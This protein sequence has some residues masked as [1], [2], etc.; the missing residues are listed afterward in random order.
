M[1]NRGND[2]EQANKRYLIELLESI[3]RPG[4]YC[5][6]GNL[7]VP[8]PQITLKNMGTLSFPV[9]LE[10]IEA[11]IDMAERAPYGKGT[12][13][14]MDMSVR[15]CWQIDARQIRIS[16]KAWTNSFKK[17]MNLVSKG[18]GIDQGQ[19]GAKLYKLLIYKEG[20]F[21][22]A[23]RDTEKVPRMIATLSLSLPTPGEGGELSVR[24]ADLESVFNMNA[25]EPSELS[26]A[27]F[28]ADCLHEVRPVTKGHRIS[29]VYNLFL[30]SEKKWTGAPD[31]TELRDKVEK[32]LVDWIDSGKTEKIVWMLAHS[33]SE[34]GLSFDTL[35]GTDAAVARVLGEAADHAGCDMHTATLHIQ[36]TGTPD[37]DYDDSY[38]S[39]PKIGSTIMEDLDREEHLENWTAHDGSH[40]PFGEILV[41]TGELLPID[42]TD[43]LCPDE[44]LLEEYMGNY[45]PTL[46]L[47]YRLGALVVWP[48]SNTLEIIARGGIG[49]AVSW[50]ATRCDHVSRAE[51]HRLLSKLMDIWP[52]SRD[53]YKDHNR[54]VMLQILST[55]GNADLA[56]DF[57]DQTVLI[58]YNGSENEQLA[59][60]MPVV[61]PESAKEFLPKLV[62][63]YLLDYPKE[64]LALCT[65]IT[66]TLGQTEPA[67]FN[68]MRDVV[69]SVLSLLRTVLEKATE[70]V[71]RVPYKEVQGKIEYITWRFDNKNPLD[72]AAICDLFA[73]TWHL[74]LEQESVKA[75]TTIAEFTKA[76]T[77]DRMLPEALIDLYKI[78]QVSSTETYRLLWRQSVDI[79]TQRS[80][81]PP[82]KPTNWTINANVPGSS[83]LL[84]KLQAFCLNPNRRTI[85]FKVAKASRRHIHETIKVLGLDIDHTTERKGSPHTLHC[86]KN[87][88]GHKRRLAEYSEDIRYIEHL[89]TLVPKGEIENVDAKR[90][91]RLEAAKAAFQDNQ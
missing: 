77:P 43:H 61:G 39:E 26:Y 25:Q 89:L 44:E 13:T 27:A 47:I 38:W 3:D 6:G 24:H 75:A 83:D 7:H 14:L 34:E 88:N 71:S 9:P 87:R 91:K 56:K 85:S 59:G 33:Y 72:S 4:E 30:Q 69:Q 11:L 55:T 68:V 2:F 54:P 76:T 40:P 37:I 17:I 81:A 65:M 74:G 52:E 63:R 32:C 82:E 16:G 21:F 48:K 15:D 31:Y 64:I 79:L 1:A 45:G 58:H 18:L 8:M 28:Y 41:S 60:L 90:I 49:H 19:L 84:V 73:L 86:T 78:E 80:S 66:E 62:E 5:V 57:L 12:K 42:S 10:Q 20:G 50:V 29:L 22:A 67:W 35:K 70:I 36:E 46:D 23:H 51:M 53:I